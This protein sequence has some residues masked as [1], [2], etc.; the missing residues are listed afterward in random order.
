MPPSRRNAQLDG[1]RGYAAL[2]VVVFH[3]ILGVD[4]SQIDRILYANWSGLQSRYDIF[5]K[6][7]LKVFDGE[8]AVVLFFV[9]SGAVLFHS[10]L[11]ETST[12]PSVSVRFLVRRFFR[13]Y[14]ALLVCICVCYLAFDLAGRGL[15]F[16]QLVENAALYDFP[17]NGATWTLQTEFIAAPLL[18][19]CYL[20]F[21]WKA[22][23]GAGLVIVGIVLFLELKLPHLNT[24]RAFW[25][26]FAMG[27]LIPMR[28]GRWI[29][30]RAPSLSWIL[31]LTLFIVMKSTTQHVAA[32]ALILLAY[33]ARCGMLGRF[34][35]LPVSQFFGRISYSFYLFN[36][37]VLEIVCMYLRSQPWAVSHPLEVGFCASI[38]IGALTIPI[39]V[40]A[41]RFVEVPFNSFGHRISSPILSTS[42]R[43]LMRE[44]T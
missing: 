20:G 11:R 33:Y 7:T 16:E 30:T 10:L 19:C 22:E 2:F 43:R 28:V 21:L 37:L 18:L 24:V 40:V 35:E 14:P 9:M 5:T 13:V 34:L 12:F 32:A 39:A 36:V 29:G 15:T 42:D 17:I 27:A 25:P 44:Q 31:A 6:I 8:A 3:S 26:C 4:P 38:I 23:I 1:L 41:W